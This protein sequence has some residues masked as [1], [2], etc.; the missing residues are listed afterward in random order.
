M[1]NLVKMIL[2]P[3]VSI[4]ACDLITFNLLANY[5]PVMIGH[6]LFSASRFRKFIERTVRNLNYPPIDNFSDKDAKEISI[7]QNQLIL[8]KTMNYIREVA[9]IEEDLLCQPQTGDYKVHSYCPRCLSQFTQEGGTC[10]DC[11]GVDLIAL[12]IPEL[13]SNESG[14]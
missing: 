5:N 11:Q 12:K 14:E 2:C 7:W 1:N 4:R 8:K 13:R 6:L 9:N 10:P 3:P